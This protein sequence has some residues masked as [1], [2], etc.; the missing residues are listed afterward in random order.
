M[1]IIKQK[2][3]K[4]QI[5]CG[6]VPGTSEWERHL[7]D[8]ALLEQKAQEISAF[9]LPLELACLILQHY[10]V[11]WEKREINNAGA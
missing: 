7:N 4:I 5:E 9:P 11:E 3:P 1:S 6:T 10:A 8:L 2:L